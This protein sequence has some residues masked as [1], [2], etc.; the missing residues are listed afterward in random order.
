MLAAMELMYLALLSA[1]TRELP[2]Q[3]YHF[4]MVPVAFSSWY[5]LILAHDN[6]VCSIWTVEFES[7][8]LFCYTTKLVSRLVHF[9]GLGTRASFRKYSPGDMMILILRH[10]WLKS[11]K[12]KRNRNT[13]TTMLIGDMKAVKYKI[14]YNCIS[15]S[16]AKSGLTSDVRLWNANS[17]WASTCNW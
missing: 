2:K 12:H 6:T 17:T 4:L 15:Q 3:C 5:F 9:P 11:W 10:D 1:S 16:I 14:N 7:I 13:P 8:G